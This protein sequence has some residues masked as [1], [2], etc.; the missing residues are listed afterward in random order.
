MK[1]KF[2]VATVVMCTLVGSSAMAA[3]PIPTFDKE[4]VTTHLYNRT[5]AQELQVENMQGAGELYKPGNTGTIAHPAFFVSK[6]K[7]TGYSLPDTEGKLAAICKQYEGRSLQMGE[8]QQLISKINEYARTCGFTVAQAVVPPQEVVQGELEIMVYVA[9]YDDIKIVENESDVADRVLQ[10]YIH[11]NLKSG[12]YIMD[13][14]LELAM[15]NIN[16]LPGVI[17]R[18]VLAP[19]SAPGTTKVLVQVKRRPVWNNYIFTD[20]AGGYYSGRYRYGFNTEITNPGHQ[21][22]KIIINGMLTNHDTKNYGVR[23]EAPVGRDGTR[24]GIGWSQSSY[25][26]H[27]NN[28]YDSLGKSTGISFYGFTPVYRDRM[29]RVTAIYGFDHRKI[30]DRLHFKTFSLPELETDKQANV[31]HVGISGSQYYPNRFTQYNLIYWN[32]H[33][34]GDATMLNGTYHKLTSD[35]LHVIYDGKTNY[36]VQFSGQLGNRNLDGSELF[37]LGG[38]NGVRAYGPSEGSG[39]SGFTAT[40]EVRRDL[41]I[42]GLAAAVFVD[43]GAVKT[44][45]SSGAQSS[46]EHLSGYGVGLRYN[47]DNDWHAQL[48]YAR[49]INA[50]RDRV[51]PR[52]HDGRLWFQVYK[53][54]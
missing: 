21:G 14:P 44:H 9:K 3:S 12:E 33:L 11:K 47:L 10:G 6:I 39:D 50:Q 18:A 22:D 30:K 31:F 5:G 8:L 42:K 16:D 43:T 29:N 37:Y 25:D 1:E 4:A 48:D 24:W 23:Y 15:N 38:M 34:S 46:I 54:F 41:G 17:A 7:L 26:I 52:D 53:M 20:N 27:P 49:K 36:R 13:K 40:A 45:A 19:G 32:G 2:F 35:L 51:T 28:F